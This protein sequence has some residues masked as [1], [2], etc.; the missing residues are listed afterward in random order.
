M[1]I[2]RIPKDGGY[3]FQDFDGFSRTFNEA[4]PSHRVLFTYNDIDFMAIEDK[5]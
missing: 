2:V 1:L 5:G 4:F 3:D